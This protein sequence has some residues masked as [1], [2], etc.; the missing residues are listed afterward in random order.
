VVNQGVDAVLNILDRVEQIAKETP[1]IDNSGS[2]F[3]NPAFRTFYD[4][5]GDVSQQHI[6]ENSSCILIILK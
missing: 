4:K 6:I 5:V 1:P 2:R 3:G